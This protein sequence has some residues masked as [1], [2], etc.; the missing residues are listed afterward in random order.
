MEIDRWDKDLGSPL[1]SEVL[2]T[3]ENINEDGLLSGEEFIT[4]TRAITGS[5]NS[6]VR[7]DMVFFT[8]SGGGAVW[9][10]GSISWATSLLW[11]NAQ[12]S[13]S[14]SYRKRIK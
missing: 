10:T 14:K 6:K 9:S 3:S 12:N 11:N 5:T 2:A 1:D 4:T 7:A 8:T 13:V